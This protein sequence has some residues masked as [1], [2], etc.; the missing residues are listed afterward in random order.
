MDVLKFSL[1]N[2][3]LY[4]STARLMATGIL[5]TLNRD[6]EEIEDIKMALTESLNI[7]LNLEMDE[8]IDIVFEIDEKSLK[9]K[10]S[11]IS[12]EKLNSC[13]KLSLARTIIDYLID[14][15]YFEENTLVLEKNL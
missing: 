5:S 9:I 7:C 13:E 1:P 3:T 12:E 6:I 2:D 4:F 15:S 14:E 10:V 8:N 11:Q